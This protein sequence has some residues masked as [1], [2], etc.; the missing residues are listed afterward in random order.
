MKSFATWAESRE[1]QMQNARDA[2]RELF[3]S[4]RLNPNEIPIDE[5][6]KKLTDL[7]LVPMSIDAHRFAAMVKTTFSGVST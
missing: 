5:L 3:Y 4:H 2:A 1:D 6:V 7:E